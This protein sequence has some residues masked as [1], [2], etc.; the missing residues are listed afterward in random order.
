MIRFF[1]TIRR[2][3]MAQGRVTRYFTYAIGEILLVVI[4]ILIALQLNNWNE[5]SK[6]AALHD[7][8]LL[9]LE[10]E[11]RVLEPVLAGLVSFAHSSHQSTAY[12]VNA[13]RL[14][15]PPHDERQFRK[16]LARSNW[17]QNVPQIATSYQELVST[18]RLS[19]IRDVE[20]RKALIRYGDAHERLERI[21]PV[22]TSVIFAPGSNY[23]RAV[24]WN[25]DPATWEGEGGIVSYDWNALRASRAEMQGWVAYQYDLALYAE[26]ELLEIRIVLSHLS[27]IQ[28]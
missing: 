6:K 25:M 14:E 16:A 3:M 26:K 2:N 21:Y 24:D 28:K 13:L 22:A 15:N 8:M 12:V 23:Y 27:A 18:G 11:F 1:R 17:V 10:E 19:D 7:S 5:A 4:G 20:L 9:R